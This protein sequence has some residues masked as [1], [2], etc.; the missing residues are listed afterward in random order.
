MLQF[1]SLL[2]DCPNYTISIIKKKSK[3]IFFLFYVICNIS[4]SAQLS[5]SV[6]LLP[7][8]PSSSP[9][10]ELS[11]FLSLTHLKLPGTILPR[12]EILPLSLTQLEGQKKI[13]IK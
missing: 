3:N 8:S 9:Y 11:L 2:V 1:L 10:L 5:T 12:I 7:S 6:S 13:K 4:S